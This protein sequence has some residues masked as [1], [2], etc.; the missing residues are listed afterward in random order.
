M[1]VGQAQSVVVDGVEYLYT[2]V[3]EWT[4]PWPGADARGK[5][6]DVTVLQRATIE[7][8]IQIARLRDLQERPN[9]LVPTPEWM[10]LDAFLVVNWA[11]VYRNGT[12]V[13]K[14]T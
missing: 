11:I 10:L 12:P 6:T 2:D 5:E 13:R 9:A 8:V 4:D 3:V 7:G 14:P 1:S